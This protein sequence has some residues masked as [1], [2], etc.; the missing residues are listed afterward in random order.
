[1]ASSLLRVGLALAFTL[2]GVLP[3]V[4]L[5]ELPERKIIGGQPAAIAQAPWQVALVDTSHS[6]SPQ[7]FCGGSIVDA[8]HVVTAAHCL[9]SPSGWTADEI[10][11]GTTLLS[12][13]QQVVTVG[14]QRLHPG[15]SPDT[16]A[17]DVAVL[18]LTTPLTLDDVSTQAVQLATQSPTAGAPL[19]VSGWG[20]ASN[21]QGF[22]PNQLRAVIVHAVTDTTCTASYG[23][24][25]ITDLMLC[26]GE[27][28]GGKDSC[29]GDSGG[30]IVN[31]GT[32]VLVGIV[33]FGYQCALTGYPGI[34]T[35]VAAT[36]VR[37]FVQSATG[38]TPDPVPVTPPQP[39]PVPP[40]SSPA[41]APVPQP[42]DTT[43]PVASVRGS[44]CTRTACTLAIHVADPGFSRGVRGVE[45][46]VRSQRA[47]HCRLHRKRTRCIRTTAAR[48]LQGI[49]T[50]LDTYNLRATRLPAG[51][52]NRFSLVASDNA[53][54]R[55]PSPTVVRL[56]TKRSA[57]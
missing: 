45:A 9:V 18:T 40:P 51:A 14:E 8:T 35:E 41:P 47:A 15:F 43:P 6:S 16:L 53:G 1:V 54:Q 21:G 44:N 56:K 20:D 49:P 42:S 12:D 17:N 32:N 13:P 39:Q 3:A 19:L 34:Y 31:E 5:A 48:T 52:V 38:I 37:S 24:A 29:S 27:P 25:L 33:S 55:Q 28:A 10:Y 26:A 57:R 30:P 2:F 7:Q 22:Y 23:P 11:A 50:G 46:T 4:A 36:P